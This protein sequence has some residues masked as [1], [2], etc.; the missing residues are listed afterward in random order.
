MGG[1]SVIDS[2]D[3][4]SS[5]HS[6]EINSTHTSTSTDHKIHLRRPLQIDP[7]LGVQHDQQQHPATQPLASRSLISSASPRSQEH[8]HRAQSQ[9]ARNSPRPA[10]PQRRRRPRKRFDFVPSS[11]ELKGLAEYAKYRNKE[12]KIPEMHFNHHA[13][14][15]VIQ[16]H[17]HPRYTSKK[18]KN[19]ELPHRCVGW[20]VCVYVCGWGVCVVHLCMYVMR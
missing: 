5:S 11:Y 20:N 1:E 15:S 16:Q 8:A 12:P 3:M 4:T 18:V 14:H 6:R 7:R 17:R 19:K 10:T 13:L 2:I 9:S